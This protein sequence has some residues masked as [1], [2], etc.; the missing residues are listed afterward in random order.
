MSVER[1]TL[2]SHQL[3][4]RVKKSFHSGITSQFLE[5]E[6]LVFQSYKYSPYDECSVYEFRNEKGDVKE[7]WMGDEEMPIAW[8][9]NFEEIP[10]RVL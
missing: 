4:Y 2:F 6:I 8:T 10:A 3:K 7:W 9:E 5:G 1:S